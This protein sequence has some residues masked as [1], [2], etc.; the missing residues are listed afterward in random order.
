DLRLPV[1]DGWT[2]LDRLKHDSRTR[3]IPVHLISAM[4]EGKQRALS[5]GAIA[6]LK[7]PVT[8]EALADAMNEVKG[9]VERR[10]KNL[11][12][13][14]DDA[15]QRKAIIELIGNGDVVT[16]AVGSA[17]ECLAELRSKHFDCMVLDLGLPDDDGF[18]LIERIKADDKLGALPIIIYTGRELAQDE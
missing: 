11:L 10:V 5:L 9:F 3:H 4:D 16:T 6:F 2:V 18:D 13:V 12:V 1:V 7:K 17:E 14:E 8:A 15:T